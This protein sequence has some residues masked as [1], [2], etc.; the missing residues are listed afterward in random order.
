MAH[1]VP[2]VLQEL[3]RSQAG[4]I[5]A[6]Q[7]IA[8]GVGTHRAENRV[9]SGYWQRPQRG[10]YVVFSGPVPPLTRIW[11]ALLRCGRDAALSHE[12]A[13]ELDGLRDNVPMG[14]V[15]V[16]VP[17]ERHVRGDLPGVRVHRVRGLASRVH[18]A[19]RPPRLRIEETV[20]DLVMQASSARV[21]ASLVTGAVQRRL[22][23]PDR[24]AGSAERRAALPRRALFDALVDDAAEGAESPLEVWFYRRVE[25]AHRLPTGRRQHRSLAGP[26][27]WV[28]VDYDAWR[29]RVELDGRMGH[30]GDGRFRDRL[31]DN[32]S[33][34]E[35]RATLRYGHAEV[36]DEPCEIA[37]E[38]ASVL[39]GN[40]WQGLIC[41]CGPQC[42]LR[43]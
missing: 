41:P 2:F 19:R 25:R 30:E 33:T 7:L 18:P 42:A 12:T 31:R 22:T 10:I 4:V 26:A 3:A 20:V 14:Q 13:A 28:D 23:T 34:V 32:H 16:S 17:A 43:S 35:G 24:L 1:D 9:R 38:V 37:T 39:S 8:A 15:H 6:G 36:F 40:G 21:V 29:V 27:R 11:A 5:T